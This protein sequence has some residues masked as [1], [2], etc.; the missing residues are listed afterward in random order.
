MYIFQFFLFGSGF[1]RLRCFWRS[2]NLQE[3]TDYIQS[4]EKEKLEQKPRF[5]SLER[6]LAEGV[7][8]GGRRGEGRIFLIF[9]V[10]WYRFLSS[11]R[12]FRGF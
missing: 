9:F 3:E 10:I 11:E 6:T 5:F 8:R 4:S 2:L 12:H 1:Y 7:G